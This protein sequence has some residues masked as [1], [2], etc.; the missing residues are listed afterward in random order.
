MQDWITIPDI[1]E[2]LDLKVTR[3]HT[4]ISERQLLAVRDVGGVRRVPALFMR[5]DRVLESLKG[6][7]VV[8]ADSG[9]SDEEAI[10]WLY[11]ADES[12]PGRPI[13]ALHDGRKTEV[14]RRAQALAW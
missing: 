4:L 8:L 13:D 1:A 12:L 9:F 3:V 2:A 5:E 6:T 7:L 14:R 10:A 11:T